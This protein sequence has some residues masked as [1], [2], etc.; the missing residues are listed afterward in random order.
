MTYHERVYAS[1]WFRWAL[2]TV[3]T[4]SALFAIAGNLAGDAWIGLL[5]AL[6]TLTLI[7]LVD[8]WFMTMQV[9]VDQEAVTARFGPFATRL[10]HPRIVSVEAQDYRWITYGGWGIRWGTQRRR[11]WSVPFLNRGVMLA[12]T[13]GTRYFI[14]SRSPEDLRSSIQEHIEVRG[15][16]RG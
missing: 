1:P 13:D 9:T 16:T 6:F 7:I 12:L 14:S 15:G 5:A 2:W 11:A 3:L 4:A 10:A 8:R